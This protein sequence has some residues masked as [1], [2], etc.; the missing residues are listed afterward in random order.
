MFAL[1]LCKTRPVKTGFGT[2]AHNCFNQHKRH[3]KYL[4]FWVEENNEIDK[5]ET[6]MILTFLKCEMIHIYSL[7]TKKIHNFIEK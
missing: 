5:L 7:Q 2:V 3:E 1:F 6:T 4:I